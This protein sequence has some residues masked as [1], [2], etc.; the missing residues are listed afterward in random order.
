MVKTWIIK[1]RPMKRFRNIYF[2][3]PVY[4]YYTNE[5]N[6]EIICT[7]N[8]ILELNGLEDSVQHVWILLLCACSYIGPGYLQK[9]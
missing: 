7:C 1:S 4:N 5:P 2:L 6:F 8:Y 9:V 3:G